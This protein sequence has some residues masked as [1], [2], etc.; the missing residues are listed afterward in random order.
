MAKRLSRDD[1]PK[2]FYNENGEG[3]PVIVNTVGELKK[4]LNE[5]PD[6]IIINQ[7]YSDDGGCQITVFNMNPKFSSNPHLE[8]QE[9]E[10][11]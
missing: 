1:V 10:S 3:Y 6:D 7:G 2:K 8:F 11:W 4:A 5:L 9:N